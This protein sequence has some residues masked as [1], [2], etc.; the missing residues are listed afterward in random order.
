[1][2]AAEGAGT[3]FID[4]VV[5]RTDTGN[6]RALVKRYGDRIRHVR[7]WG[8]LAWDGT[9]WKTDAEKEVQQLCMDV[10]RH[11]FDL[12]PDEPNAAERKKLFKHGERSHSQPRLSAMMKCAQSE[13]GVDAKA[14]DFDRDEWLL[15]VANGTIDLREGV[16]LPHSELDMI[17]KLAPINFDPNAECPRFMEFLGRIFRSQSNLIPFLQKVFGYALTGTGK[18]RFFFVF[19]GN[20]RN[21]KTTLLEA[22]RHVM[23]DYAGTIPISAL[24]KGR[25]VNNSAPTPEIANLRGRR[26]VTSSEVEDG[27]R[28]GEA[29]IKQLTG[30]GKVVARALYENMAEF[31]IT[32]KLFLDCNYKPD[33]RGGDDAIWDRTVVVPF[34]ERI[35]DEEVDTDLLEKLKDEAPGI[36]AWAVRGCYQYQEDGLKQPSEVEDAV[37]E[38]RNDS[39]LFGRFIDEYCVA[40]PGA[41]V[42]SQNLYKEFFTF[43]KDEVGLNE[44]VSKNKFSREMKRRGFARAKKG[45]TPTLLA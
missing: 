26:F 28:L 38:F 5:R 31:N 37:H 44:P 42:S 4:I 9:R 33:V 27:Q 17:T 6:G 15:N 8:W 21:G 30:N 34:K 24:M 11:V 7:Q 10:A 45:E 41:E 43:C 22:F 12:L 14:T 19:F 13:P 35:E 32:F 36:L 23:G 16:L 1:M 40:H 2:P 20:G 29:L 18:E 3:D 39:D 25:N